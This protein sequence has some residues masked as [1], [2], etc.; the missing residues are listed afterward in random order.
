M[1]TRKKVLAVG[2]SLTCAALLNSCATT[3]YRPVANPVKVPT[4]TPVKR[5]TVKGAFKSDSLNHRLGRNPKLTVVFGGGTVQDFCSYLQTLGI[6]AVASPTAQLAQVGRIVGTYSL[7]EILDMAARQAQVYWTNDG[8]V[9]EFTAYKTVVYRLPIPTK[10]Q[11]KALYS[12]YSD[13]AI[14]TG[15][16]WEE[17]KDSLSDFF[18][19]YYEKSKASLNLAFTSESATEAQD[20]SRKREEKGREKSRDW[21]SE[22]KNAVATQNRKE[23]T[24]TSSLQS[25]DSKKSLEGTQ[26]GG[27]ARGRKA[28]PTA[29]VAVNSN[30]SKENKDLKTATKRQNK[31]IQHSNLKGFAAEAKRQLKIALLKQADSKKASKE[32]LSRKI[33]AQIVENY[34]G[35]KPFAVFPQAGIVVARVSPATEKALD[36]LIESFRDRYSALVLVRFYVIESKSS[37]LKDFE[38]SLNLLSRRWK[39]ELSASISY[40]SQASISFTSLSDNYLSGIAA[41]IDITSLVNYLVERTHSK[42]LA[43]QSILTVPQVLGRFAAYTAIPYFEPQNVSV[44][45]TNPTLSYSLKFLKDG[46]EIRV[47]PSLF[48]NAV[49]LNLAVLENRYL[50]DKTVNV[51][52]MG[53]I[54]APIQAPRVLNDTCVLKSGQVLIVGGS[55]NYQDTVL[56]SAN[57]GI[58]TKKN[59][60]SKANSLLVLAQVFKIPISFEHPQRY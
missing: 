58:P 16:P 53:N 34:D 8:G 49:M 44:G 43:S 26:A 32:G 1:A 40:G 30:K 25:L 3:Q 4:P 33:E 18:K 59:K 51:G 54:Q 24:A 14:E 17:I 42:I 36:T 22:K 21:R 60:S 12:I 46:I 56:K 52:Q 27:V 48:G 31:E 45:G 23:D 19:A 7:K 15:Q 41:G 28:V 20:M 39:K 6:P 2:A 57:V 50:G 13:D 11:L 10:E 29:Q 37:S 38:V 9:I 5:I 55:A 35:S 47:V